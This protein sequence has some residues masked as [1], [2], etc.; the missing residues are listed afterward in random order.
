MIL[1]KM[2][3]LIEKNEFRHTRD[4]NEFF[5]SHSLLASSFFFNFICDYFIL[6]ETTTMHIDNSEM[7]FPLTRDQNYPSP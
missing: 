2:G 7:V 4:K 5:V 3:K 6:R 1:L